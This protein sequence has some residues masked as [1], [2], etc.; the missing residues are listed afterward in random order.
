MVRTRVKRM[1]A[2]VTMMLFASVALVSTLGTGYATA[3]GIAGPADG[4][5][6]Q[7]ANTICALTPNRQAVMR[8]NGTPGSWTQIGGP[9]DKLFGGG[10]GLAATNPVSHD[11]YRYLGTPGRWERAGGPGYTFAYSGVA[12][13]GLT[14]FNGNVMR[15]N[16]VPGSW[17]Q[18]GGSAAWIYA[19][20]GGLAAR[21]PGSEDIYRYLGTPWQWERAGGPGR[22]FVFGAG[23]LYG[24]A[25]DGSGVF[26][27]NGVPGSWTQ[28]GGP[29]F[30]AY[31][32][33]R[34]LVAM[35]P[36][37]KYGDLYL[38]RGQWRVIR[39]S[40][41]YGGFVV[42]QNDIFYIPDNGAYIDQLTWDGLWR[43]VGGPTAR[44]LGGQSQVPCP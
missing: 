28:I 11:V 4:P 44:P 12:L 29:A 32:G 38:G 21:T 30:W 16:G 36:L 8:Y 10:G 7:V 14:G 42:T 5:G 31:G 22:S 26:A 3:T 27:Y 37:G 24:V 17:T 23:T 9:A 40:L 1:A 35:G 18:I 34:G 20:E 41:D 15:Y 39:S 6:V 25:P 43:R 33:G 13:Y 19:G 2:A